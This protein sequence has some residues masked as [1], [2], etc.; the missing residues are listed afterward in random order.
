[1]KN[2]VALALSAIFFLS[3]VSFF[4]GVLPVSPLDA[5][6]VYAIHTYK[7]FGLR[8]GSDLLWTYGPLGYLAMPL[9]IKDHLWHYYL[10]QWVVLG[11]FGMLLYHRLQK[12][13]ILN[14]CLFLFFAGILGISVWAKDG[15]PW[16]ATLLNLTVLLLLYQDL[17]DRKTRFWAPAIFL[18]AASLYAKFNLG[19]SLGLVLV[20]YLACY[21]YLFRKDYKGLLK[22][23]LLLFLTHT[24]FIA[25]HF[26]SPA[27]FLYWLQSS[28][29]IARGYSEAMAVPSLPTE[30]WVTVF[31]LLLHGLCCFK[32]WDKNRSAGTLFWI[33]SSSLILFFAFKH[34]FVRADEEHLKTFFSL[35]P[36]FIAVH[37]LW[38]RD[39]YS[40][41]VA[42][43]ALALGLMAMN[44][45]DAD[46]LKT[47][48]TAWRTT[49]SSFLQT[50]NLPKLN[51][52]SSRKNQKFCQNYHLTPEELQMAGKQSMDCLPFN[53]I[54]LAYTSA[55]WSPPPCMQGYSAYTHQLDRINAD[56]WD[57]PKAA[58]CITYDISSLDKR[59]PFFSA[60]FE[61]FALLRNYD[62]LRRTESRYLLQR[63][64]TPLTMSATLISEKQL[65]FKEMMAIPSSDQ[66]I[67]AKIK[68]EYTWLGKLL[69]TFYRSPVVIIGLR[70]EKTGVLR[71]ARIIPETAQHGL[72]INHLPAELE[73]YDRFFKDKNF[74]RE[75]R[76]TATEFLITLNKEFYFFKDTFSVRLEELRFQES[77]PL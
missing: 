30:N 76:S 24:L 50:L 26:H 37:L 75:P 44:L 36:L 9:A 69:K 51:E 15:S 31:M 17:E 2:K 42:L 45:R 52:E 53:S 10:L 21:A 19:V 14:S 7:D 27:D 11:L 34:S 59:H 41:W 55:L 67:V 63:R 73:Q 56:H 43:G 8:F 3:G 1:M 38:S 35:A 68:L 72:L 12:N 58:G 16:P 66:I 20:I 5:S 33:L 6:W 40:S 23:F 74:L 48:L 57:S 32:F 62:G 4:T 64:K 54:R 49:P 39:R 28:L 61:F 70:D 18:G 29:D 71:T 13:S 47:T 77:N 22:R 46:R 25:Y 60:P 65:R